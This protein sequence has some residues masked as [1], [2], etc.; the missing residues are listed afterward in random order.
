MNQ[1]QG[2]VVVLDRAWIDHGPQPDGATLGYVVL[3]DAD[4]D[5]TR[6]Y[7]SSPEVVVVSQSSDVHAVCHSPSQVV[8]M[9]KN[10]VCM[11]I[12]FHPSDHMLYS[13]LQV[14]FRHAIGA[15][16]IVTSLS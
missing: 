2:F 9:M 13:P 12:V 5:K 11:S 8:C 6:N 14:T 16:L 3:P 7:A 10:F 4:L 1:Q 15:G